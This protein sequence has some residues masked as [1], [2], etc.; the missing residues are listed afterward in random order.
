MIN[1]DPILLFRQWYLEAVDSGIPDPAIM[2]LATADADGKPSARILLLKDFDD[3]GY[4]FYTNYRSHKA[5]QLDRNPWAALVIHWHSLGHQV[6][7]EGRVEKITTEESDRYF[8]TRP[9]GSQL[10][11]WA[12]HQS[13]TISSRESLSEAIHRR[14]QEFKNR[15]VPRPPYWGGYR[16]IPVR[17][18]FWV[19]REDR[20]HDRIVYERD[21]DGWTTQLLAP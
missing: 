12:S 14:K 9:R 8:A 18:E 10:G 5:E 13:Q 3:R 4:V 21:G 11:T 15:D 1:P 20:M 19:D 7:I 2:T 6:R 16:L 17:I